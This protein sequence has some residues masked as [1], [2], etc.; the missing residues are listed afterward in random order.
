MKFDDGSKIDTEGTEPNTF[1][2]SQIALRTT[3]K[4]I[5]NDLISLD[6]INEP[7][8]GNALK[9]RYEQ[10]DFYTYCGETLITVNPY[11]QISHNY[12]IEQKRLY[13]KNLESSFYLM[14]TA[15][16]RFWRRFLM[17]RGSKDMSV[18][19]TASVQARASTV[20]SARGPT[21]THASS[22]KRPHL[23]SSTA[24]RQAGRTATRG[25]RASKDA[26]MR[27]IGG[28]TSKRQPTTHI[29]VASRF[30]KTPTPQSS[31]PR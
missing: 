2:L 29:C 13:K 15:A 27:R 4:L 6:Y 7:E 24:P 17:R 28:P 23:A 16:T 30:A 20:T 1:H 14:P 19:S 3:N 26:P 21:A 18:Q 12:T 10:D 22:P 11:T 31:Q 5:V 9:N 25:W 8:I